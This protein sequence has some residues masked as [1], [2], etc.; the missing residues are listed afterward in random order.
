[1]YILDSERVEIAFEGA[2]LI[3]VEQFAD[4][5]F[6]LPVHRHTFCRHVYL[7]VGLYRDEHFAQVYMVPGLFEHLFLSRRQFVYMFIYAFK[8]AVAAYEFACAYFAYALDARY[9]VGCVAAYCQHIY[10]LLRPVY[11]VFGADSRAVEDFGI[12]T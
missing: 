5:F 9:V 2:E 3:E 7:Y 1:M 8:A 10:D 11:A 12:R 6:H 4:A